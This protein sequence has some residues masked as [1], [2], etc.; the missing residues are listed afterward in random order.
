LSSI[1]KEIWDEAAQADWQ[2]WAGAT[3][4][5]LA[6]TL[7]AHSTFAMFDE[8]NPIDLA[9]TVQEFKIIG[10]HTGISVFTIKVLVHFSSLSCDG[11][12]AEQINKTRLS[13]WAM[14]QAAI[15]RGDLG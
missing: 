8:Q 11:A 4:G 7:A 1:R 12:A 9:G 3:L 15:K 10:T 13:A 2:R 5:A 14:N 6:S